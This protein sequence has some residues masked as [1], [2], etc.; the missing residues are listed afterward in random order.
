MNGP[1][2]LEPRNVGP[3]TDMLSALLPVPGFGV[4]P[5]NA[6]LVR[7]AQ[8]MLIDTGLAGLRSDF[9]DRLRSTIDPRDLRWIWITHTDPDHLGNLAAVLEEAPQARVVTTYLGMGKMGLHGLP[10]D[11]VYLL[12]PGQSLDLGD[13]RITAV[14]PPTFDAPETTGPFDKKTGTLFS[15]DCFGAL[16]A[17]PAESANDL[18]PDT[19][20]DGLVTWTTVDA[21]WLHQ[22]D[23]R[24]FTETLAEVRSLDPKLVLSSHLPPAA[25]MTETLIAHLASARTAGPFVGPDQA[26]IERMMTGVEA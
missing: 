3:E 24:L 4:L 13:R 21:P 10:L 1:S 12:N 25:G 18:A 7:A 22:V 8:P 9:L 16:L 26:A 5:V 2:M 6:F 11:R 14:R 17:A 23:E 19:L 20:R 15:A